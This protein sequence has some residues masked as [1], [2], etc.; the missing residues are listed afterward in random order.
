MTRA[1]GGQKTLSFSTGI[2]QPAS[3]PC[4]R[5]GEAVTPARTVRC[6]PHT[7]IYMCTVRST[8]LYVPPLRRQGTN[9]LP[10]Y[11]A[12]VCNCPQT[13]Q[14]FRFCLPTCCWQIS[15][16]LCLPDDGKQIPIPDTARGS[17]QSCLWTGAN[18]AGL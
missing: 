16:M 8:V 7:P 12:S 1:G 15:R 11:H 18:T 9:L 3:Q 5:D 17:G 4:A 14:R 10:L 2:R 13:C 6:I